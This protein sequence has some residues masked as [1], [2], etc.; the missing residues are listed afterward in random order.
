[1]AEC[2]EPDNV[3]D[4]RPVECLPGGQDLCLAKHICCPLQNSASSRMAQCFLFNVLLSATRASDRVR[5]ASNRSADHLVEGLLELLIR[6]HRKHL[7]RESHQSMLV[8]EDQ[9][10]FPL[11]DDIETRQ[12]TAAAYCALRI[13]EQLAKNKWNQ[14]RLFC[15]GDLVLVFS[16]F[17]A[18]SAIHRIFVIAILDAVAGAAP[19]LSEINQQDVLDSLVESLLT[20]LEKS[21]KLGRRSETQ[22][23][24]ELDREIDYEV[25]SKSLQVL[26]NYTPEWGVRDG[27][28]TRFIA[29]IAWAQSH[30][31]EIVGTL[32]ED[33]TRF[34]KCLVAASCGLVSAHSSAAAQN[35]A[36]VHGILIWLS[37]GDH[38]DNAVEC[39]RVMHDAY[40]LNAYAAEFHNLCPWHLLS[41]SH[42]SSLAG[43]VSDILNDRSVT[44][45]HMTRVALL[46][47]QQVEVDENA[48]HMDG[49]TRQLPSD[50]LDIQSR[51]S[52]VG[53]LDSHG[54]GPRDEDMLR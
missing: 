54:Q 17:L 33:G 38:L 36:F 45:N 26:S 46:Q 24:R 4:G 49:C 52:D 13:L 28:I 16:S 15:R 10:P 47:E 12:D 27:T 41:R 43:M 39:F 29:L 1:M 42:V 44:G 35:P 6:F 51:T 21:A 9:L 5:L 11:H 18:H 22:F 3:T 37:S 40:P 23:P 50:S 53:R 32:S 20:R 7:G 19:L 2:L 34:K 48:K 14:G 8:S 25:F 31:D 30:K